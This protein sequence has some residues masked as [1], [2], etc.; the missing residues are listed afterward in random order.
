[1]DIRFIRESR[2][3]LT[4]LYSQQQFIFLAGYAFNTA[5]PSSNILANNTVNKWVPTFNTLSPHTPQYLLN[6]L[7]DLLQK[8][9]RLK[10]TV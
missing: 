3:S 8:M 6:F 10:H 1:V 7:P 9:Y 4:F 2:Y 5:K